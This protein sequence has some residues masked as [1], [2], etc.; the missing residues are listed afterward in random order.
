MAKAGVYDGLVNWTRPIRTLEDKANVTGFQWGVP[1][2]VKIGEKQ[3]HYNKHGEIIGRVSVSIWEIKDV[4]GR[5]KQLVKREYFAPDGSPDPKRKTSYG[6]YN[7]TLAG[8]YHGRKSRNWEPEALT[9]A[10]I[11]G[12]LKLGFSFAPGVFDNPPDES[13]RSGN[14]CASREIVLFDADE[15]SSEHPPPERIDSL[16]ARYPDLKTDFYWIGES[17]SSRT[18]L[19]PEMRFRLMLVLPRPVLR[20][21]DTLWE[22][23]I[24]HYVEKYPFIAVGVGIDKVRLSFGNGRPDCEDR[25]FGGRLTENL[26]DRFVEKARAKERTE[27]RKAERV[28]MAL[29]RQRHN[30]MQRRL[31]EKELSH[32]TG[33]VAPEMTNPI[34]A[35][36]ETSAEK[37][38]VELGIGTHLQG[39][40]WHY[41]KS[42]TPGRSFELQDGILKPYSNAMQ[43]RS[44]ETEGAKP[45]NAHRF[46]AFHEFGLDMTLEKDK[47]KLREALARWGY[48][49]SPA[50][51]KAEKE[52]QRRLACDAGI[53]NKLS[54]PLLNITSVEILR[55]DHPRL[56][57]APPPV[58][59]ESPSFRHFTREERI[60]CSHALNISP[61]AGWHGNGTPVWTTKYEH[62]HRL[63]QQFPPNGQ[64]AAVEKR[65]IWS[66]RFESCDHCGQTAAKWIDRYLLTAGVYCDGCHK[67]TRIG[68]YLEYELGRKLPNA[69]VSDYQ[70]FLGDNPDFK[71]FTL[72]DRGVLTHLAAA[73]ATGKSTEIFKGIRKRAKRCGGKGIIAVP[74]VSLARFLGHY[75]RRRDGGAAWG[76][77]HE[78]G[79]RQCCCDSENRSSRGTAIARGYTDRNFFAF[80]HRDARRYTCRY[81]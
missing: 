7:S 33:Y 50:D 17:I 64:P 45:V 59:R 6:A 11:I 35:F 39:T 36:M 54:P 9:L 60:V 80:P 18:A 58:V 72:W 37:I 40:E 2:D 52:K 25:T 69:V 53:L 67:D 48:G 5:V 29:E 19:K 4:D 62:L 78:G 56:V 49:T 76:V 26:F 13:H 46:I 74:R 65:R 47:P 75:L 1:A 68:S 23:L 10:G 31:I 44:P 24:S 28:A 42:S 22:T 8:A 16:I 63:T 55:P 20:G 12:T 51:Y 34:T 38:I 70:G 57:S 15:W 61:D 66:T 14:Y 30:R 41:N 77:W 79:E 43:S 32:R 21:Q 71:D 27:A 73:M 81:R 3:P